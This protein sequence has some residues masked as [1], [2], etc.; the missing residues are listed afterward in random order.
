MS[1]AR[2]AV[3]LI[4][5][6]ALTGLLTLYCVQRDPRGAMPAPRMGGPEGSPSPTQG[7]SPQE[8]LPVAGREGRE[9][10]PLEK[11]PLLQ[12]RVL[13]SAG[14]PIE[15]AVVSWIA[16]EAEDV[17]PNPAWPDADWG[18]LPRAAVKVTSNADG[19]FAFEAEPEGSS[20]WGSV[21]TAVRAEYRAGA[22]ELGTVRGNWPSPLQL[23]LDP[24]AAIEVH[25]RSPDDQPVEGATVHHLP[26]R[27][28]AAGR[29]RIAGFMAQT[30]VTNARGTAI[31]G[32]IHDEQVLWAE[33][34][35]LR[36]SIWRGDHPRGAITL[37]L[38]ETFAIGGTIAYPDKHEWK[39]D[40][41]GQRRILV[42]GLSNHLWRPISRILDV[43][44]GSWGSVL[45]PLGSYQRFRVRLE[46]A[47]IT[48]VEEEFQR[49][50]ANAS[51][52]IDLSA[53][54]NEEVYLFVQDE[55]ER[56]IPDATAIATWHPSA[57]S[58]QLQRV[59]GAS[60]PD[61]YL[62]LGT[63]PPGTLR[64]EV[65]APGYGYGDVEA[66]VP[67]PYA[68]LVVLP[69]ASSIQGKCLWSGS[70]VRDFEVVYWQ[71]G[72][73][74]QHR[75]RAFWDREDGSFQLDDVA[76]GEWFL[77]G[78]SGQCPGG[79]VGRV[80]VEPL[81]SAEVELE[82]VSPVLGG[83]RVLD[84]TT[85]QPVASAMIQVFT[86]GASRRAAPWGAPFPVQADGT[87]EL[88]AFVPGLNILTVEAEGYGLHEARG[89]P[90][91][92][93]LDW[94]EI[95]LHRTQEME[96]RIL[97][98]EE[99]GVEPG[100]LV[101]SSV[102]SEPPL[103][104]G[105][106]GSDGIAR[107]PIVAAGDYRVLVTHPNADW[108]RIH[109]RLDPGMEW[110]F[111]LSLGG[112]K[113]LRVLA[114]DADDNPVKDLQVVVSGQEPDGLVLRSRLPDTE[115]FAT[116][117][118]LQ[119]D[120]VQVLLVDFSGST[121]LTRDVL[122]ESGGRTTVEVR[123]GE[124][125]AR[126]RIVDAEG[127]PLVG[128]WVTI[129]S[130]DG[131]Q[132]HAVDETDSEGR[133]VLPGTPFGPVL[134]DVK[135]GAAGRRMG[136]PIDLD[137]DEIEF[138]LQAQ[139]PLEVRLLDGDLPLAGVSVRMETSSGTTLSE[140]VHTNADGR[141]RFESV[142]AGSVR[143][144]G[145][146]PDCWPVVVE[147]SIAEGE[148]AVVEAQMRRLG[149]VELTVR[150]ADGLP[151]TGFELRLQSVEFETDVAAWLE[152][153]LVR[154][155]GGLVTDGLGR[156]ELEGLPNGTYAWGPAGDSAAFGTFQVA[157]GGSSLVLH[158]PR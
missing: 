12:G 154:A 144:A 27:P 54:K 119:A 83:G 72:R 106:V 32:A 35:S 68:Q 124:R 139:G 108:E 19:A 40:Y 64:V 134:V 102:D 98:L 18:L 129:R 155:P 131:V 51:I 58:S 42:S 59:A 85:G 143:L 147:R 87:F 20:T 120:R 141:C 136:V 63:F 46:G 110:R 97:G 158:L 128:A 109:L 16:F 70:P 53:E 30:A 111:E 79:P 126:L 95:R 117:A 105:K 2:R 125:S 36:S 69:R 156:V 24:A 60:R 34:G 4:L 45:V 100:A 113:R 21:L 31:L 76:P 90:E 17:E 127:S 148:A 92:T 28:R 38:G 89:T 140:V 94:G 133:A 152:K 10:G 11:S 107:Y 26:C 47:P 8:V 103:P 50:V 14:T 23:V 104:A 1:T 146:R 37:T 151:V 39:P 57:S 135:H 101:L 48:P 84:A 145:H 121:V 80:R 44:E 88:E 153:G 66:S 67:S 71:E 81:A 77:R 114:L 41:E 150:N 29:D 122:L 5:V 74:M 78:V 149:D 137:D 25:V 6:G 112:E 138:V 62:Y 55:Q 142:G 75:R 157:P 61:G 22:L 123:L 73:A 43:D 13:S 7:R 65:T 9:P 118:G 99:L 56:P 115:G 130:R 33:H 52:R 15:G 86:P 96:L 116:F 82:I 91:G 49:P 93:M 3:I 132:I